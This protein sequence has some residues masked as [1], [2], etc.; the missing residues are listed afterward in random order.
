V[1]T[2]TE[3]IQHSEELF[4]GGQWLRPIDGHELDVL[5][6]A[7]EEP[8]ARVAL[9]G[10]ADIDAAV[11]AARRAFDSGP[12]PRMSVEERLALVT[13]LGDRLLA[14]HED[15]ARI[16]TAEVGAPIG[17]PE[18]R[19]G[20]AMMAKMIVDFYAVVAGAYPWSELRLGP[21]AQ[22]EIRRVPVGVVGAIIPWNVPLHLG[23]LKIAPALLAG[24]TVVLKVPEESPLSSLLLA[25]VAEEIGLGE[26]VLSIIPADRETSEL[27]VRNPAVDMI[28]FTGSTR[29]GKRIGAICGEALRRVTLEL[30]GK[31]AAIVL[32][33]ADLDTVMPALV[34]TTILNNGQVCFNQTRVLAPRSV[35]AEV[36]ERITAA[37]SAMAVGDPFDPE[38]AIGPL[39]S[40]AQRKRVEGYIALGRDE[41]ARITTGGGRPP[42]LTR[43]Y[44]LQ[45]TVFDCV[46]NS[47]QIAQE[48]I[49][50]PVVTVIPYASEAQAVEIA[51][52]SR[53]GL[54]GS[55]WTN[56][57]EHGKRVARQLRT[58]TVGVNNVMPDPAGT[59]GGFKESGIGRAFGPEGMSE[60][61]ELQTV[62]ANPG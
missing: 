33:D 1:S 10:K 47:M 23:I 44:Y 12:W 38:T 43:G 41:G 48:E 37:Y 28:S 55:V 4:I 16:I 24:C 62:Q 35:Y 56:D 26:G 52:D 45:P 54:S 17:P 57:V 29:A 15:V 14:R 8:I 39:I 31:S 2:T 60:Y 25:E 9:A 34:P 6:P 18:Q 20:Q 21:T 59:H 32:E 30:G 36:V 49:F 7:T 13:Q 61:V 53:Y 50:G 42:E 3:L 19:S 5:S 58:G 22:L 46:D 27:L 40:A 51:N 11:I